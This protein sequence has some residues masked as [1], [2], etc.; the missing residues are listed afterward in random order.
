MDECRDAFVQ[1]NG[2][3]NDGSDDDGSSG[4]DGSNSDGGS[5]GSGSD[6]DGGS[7]WVG[8]RLCRPV[9]APRPRPI[10]R[11]RGPRG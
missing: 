6:G 2:R 3:I 10:R 5:D 9:G 4:G 11:W 7:G 1:V 8:R